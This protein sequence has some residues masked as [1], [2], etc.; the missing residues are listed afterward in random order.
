M[1]KSI[2]SALSLPLELTLQM[3]TMTRSALEICLRL[4]PQ[5]SRITRATLSLLPPAAAQDANS[6]RRE[7]R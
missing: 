4:Q 5:P 6:P 3:M 2:R 7:E 1:Y